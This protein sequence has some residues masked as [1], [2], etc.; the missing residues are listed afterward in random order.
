MICIHIACPYTPVPSPQKLRT[1]PNPRLFWPW[2]HYP[3][4][5]EAK[6]PVHYNSLSILG[7]L[8]LLGLCNGETMDRFGM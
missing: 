7:L 8:G 6:G 3:Y 1:S 2:S 4:L 5:L